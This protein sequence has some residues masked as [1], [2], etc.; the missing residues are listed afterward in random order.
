[1]TA[2]GQDDRERLEQIAAASVYAEGTNGVSIRYGARVFSRHWQGTSCLELGP[3][4][5]LATAL[6]AETYEDITLVDGSERFA[7]ELRE[8]FPQATVIHSLFEDWEPDRQ[9][10]HIVVGCVLEHVED[11]VALLR[12]AKDWLAPGGQI[13]FCVPNA[14]SLH[15]QAGVLLGHLPSVTA[16]SEKD[17]A[18][19][20]RR[21]YTPDSLRADVTAAGLEIKT[22]GGWWLKPLSDAQIEASWSPELLDAYMQIGE[23]YPDIAAVIYAVACRPSDD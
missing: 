8:R 6:L 5:G 11:P 14:N 18:H 12:R 2:D 10:D 22:E 13:Q 4:E 19:G 21:V 9:Y 16:F 17:V 7:E 23:R 3:A 20:H 1:V 15:R